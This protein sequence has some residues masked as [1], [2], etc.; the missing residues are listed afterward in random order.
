M[1]PEIIEKAFAPIRGIPCWNVRQGHG[2]FLTLEFGSPKLKI[3]EVRL[4]SSDDPYA[5][6]RRFISLHGDSH[7]WIY[8]C[9]W[10]IAQ[11]GNVLACNESTK[12][13]IATACRALEGQA[14]SEFSFRPEPGSSRFM[15]DLGGKIS[16][17]PYD[18]E[19]LEQWMLYCADG[20][21]LTY[22]SDGLF[23]HGPGNT[24]KESFEKITAV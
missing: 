16:T 15:F 21:V 4:R 10:R 2:S 14:F 17:G 11:D 22:R 8:C 13:S 12:E 3:G 9:G 6:G 7:L 19:L 20:N 5:Y 18:D 24:S 1:S 23:S